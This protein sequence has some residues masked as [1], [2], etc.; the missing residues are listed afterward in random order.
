MDVVDGRGYWL[1]R[2]LLERGIGVICLIAFLTALNQFKPLLGEHGLLPVPLFVKQ[3]PFRESP[4][5]FFF[6]PRDFAFTAGAWLG[7]VLSCLVISGLAARYSW[8]AAGVWAAIY[9]LYLSFVN[10]GQTFYGFGWESILLEACFFAMFLGGANLVPQRIPIWIFRWL[11]FRIMFG[12]G[13]IKLRGDPCWRNL[14]CLNYYYETQPMPNP[15]SWYFHWAPHWFGKGG[16]LFNHFSELIV[17]FAYFLP[18]PF[19]GIAGIIT[20]VFQLSIIASGNLSWLNWMTLFLAFSLFDAQFFSGLI[21]THAPA[22]HAPPPLIGWLHYAIGGAVVLMSVPVVINMLS[23][24]QVM[25]SSFNTFH[26][27]G[28]YGAF[29]S[30][31]RPR[32]EVIVEGT[33]EAVLLPSTLWREY[34]FK[35]K[36]GALDYRPPQIAPYHL[37]LD[38]LMWFAAMSDYQ[39]YPWFVNFVA[40]LL[41][42]DPEVLGLLR[43]NPF[44]QH[45]PRHVR[46]MLYEYHFTTPDEHRRTGNWWKRTLTRPYFPAVSLEDP[47][48]RQIL[49]NQ[50]WVER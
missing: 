42:G 50:G 4:S 30:I 9:L 46:A 3:V 33:D 41:E 1:T 15:L 31:T 20:V 32:Y 10:V 47:S 35:G 48:F 27:V 34:Q 12:A 36:P 21:S 45:P 29:G 13:L 5:L 7:I 24:R 23:A 49:R 40:K 14:T 39:D 2:L 17:P 25:N 37:R 26:L 11:L 43:Q 16:V 22:M 6:L 38:W 18:Q 28:T 8:L 44:P 19:A